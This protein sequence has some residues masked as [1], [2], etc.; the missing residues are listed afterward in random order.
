MNEPVVQDPAS[1]EKNVRTESWY[2]R[3]DHIDEFLDIHPMLLHETGIAYAFFM[4]EYFRRDASTQMAMHP[5]M[6]QFK[7]FVD[8]EGRMWRVTGASRL[9]DVWLAKDLNR[10]H[11]YDRRVEPD[12][13]KLTG[14]RDRPS[15][16]S[17]G[18]DTKLT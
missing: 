7:L 1:E 12:F 15:I 11:G 9:G 6:K 2:R 8:F 17:W 13:T 10:D 14:W 5:F 18:R 4:F 3:F 16:A